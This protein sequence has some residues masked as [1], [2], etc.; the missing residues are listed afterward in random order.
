MGRFAHEDNGNVAVIFALGLVPL[1][2]FIGLA[3]DFGSWTHRETALRKAADAASLAGVRELASAVAEG[4]IDRAAKRAGS[5]ALTYFGTNGVGTSAI[6]VTPSLN[7]EFKVTVDVTQPAQ[8]TFSQVVSANAVNIR[9]LSEAVASKTDDAC[10][11]ALDPSAPVGVDFNLSGQVVAHNCSIWSNSQANRSI[12]GNG[13]GTV[14]SS[15]TCAVGGASASPAIG[16]Q[17]T[18]TSACLPVRDPLAQWSP[19]AYDPTCKKKHLSLEKPG[20]YTLEPGLYCGGIAIRGGAVV[21]LK[22][23]LYVMKD[24]P[25]SVTGGGA[26]S[27]FDVS[28]LLTGAKAV[29]DL[30]GASVVDLSAPTSGP[31]AG[32]VL[33]AG[34]QEPKQTSTLKGADVFRLEGHVYLPTQDL[35]YTGGPEGRVPAAYTNVVA[36]T[37]TFNGASRVEFRNNTSGGPSYAAKA[38]NGIH[39]V[40]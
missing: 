31:M 27:G 3:V 24:G 34:R 10:I 2:G 26:I 14:K 16:F 35:K 13:S 15:T 28:I 40:R 22:P 33:A 39:L 36:R 29:A 1:I 32:L 5:V 6:Q 21:T 12:S 38:F 30:G 18:V 8:K 17:P 9:V 7:Q 4:D 11:V 20:R 19:P 25:L 37:I 23:G